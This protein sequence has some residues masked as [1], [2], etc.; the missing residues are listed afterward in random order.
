[1]ARVRSVSGRS[2]ALG[3]LMPPLVLSDAEDRQV[4][5]IASSRSLSHSIVQRAQIVLTCGTGET[6]TA[7][8]NRIGLAVMTV[9]KWRKN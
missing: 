4:K 6:N 1:M 7:I 9:G 3:R 2:V 8:A 5:S